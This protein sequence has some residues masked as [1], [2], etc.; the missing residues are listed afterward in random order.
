MRPNG[1]GI[2]DSARRGRSHCG[3]FSPKLEISQL[4]LF[5]PQS[6]RETE[7]NIDDY[8]F[9]TGKNPFEKNTIAVT[10]LNLGVSEGERIDGTNYRDEED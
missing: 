9:D 3:N 5:S 10:G 7:R 4:K 2:A 8:A 1:Y 6:H